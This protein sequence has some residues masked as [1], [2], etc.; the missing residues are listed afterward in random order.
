MQKTNFL[1]ANFLMKKVYERLDHRTRTT[2]FLTVCDLVAMT[3]K[4]KDEKKEK[5]REE[6]EELKSVDK[7]GED[8]FHWEPY[9]EPSDD[10]AV[11]YDHVDDFLEAKRQHDWGG[12]F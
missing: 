3:D 1:G 8:L 6:K 2:L 10:E 5:T 12:C 4:D 9:Q 11:E 7:L